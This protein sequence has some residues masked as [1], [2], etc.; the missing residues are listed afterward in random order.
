MTLR[1]LQTAGVNTKFNL[2]EVFEIG[3]LNVME[4]VENI[5]EVE[6]TL[7]KF[8]DGYT[9]IYNLATSGAAAATL[10]GRSNQR[11]NLALSIYA[12]NGGPLAS[13]TPV[14]QCIISGGYVSQLSY[15]FSIGGFFSESVSFVANSKIWLTGGYT[16]N[17]FSAEGGVASLTPAAPEGV[18]RRQNFNWNG[19]LLP[20]NIPG[21]SS[22]GTND[23]IVTGANSGSY[24][25]S[26]QSIKISAN[27]GREELLELGRR[28]PY[29][30]YVK[31][32]VQVNTS[33]EVI[34]KTGDLVSCT[35]VG[36]YANGRNVIPYA[37]RVKD[38]EGIAID[39]GANNVLN[40]VTMSGGNAGASGTNSM[41]TFNYQTFNDLTVYHTA[42]PTGFTPTF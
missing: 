30:R 38:T 40:G 22:S 16:F 26:V 5:P 28:V 1:S 33:I 36:V 13:G 3:N 20:L 41:M 4:Q 10:I 6:V 39:L 32:P 8:L 27:L 2:E 35:D 31:F 24:G 42:D 25:A 19:S 37:M 23:P 17:G 29:F 15:N 21:V 9:P 18:N 7:E 14:Q 12:D 34:D 11:A